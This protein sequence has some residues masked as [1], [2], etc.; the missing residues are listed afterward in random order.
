MTQVSAGVVDVYVIRPYPRGRG[1]CSLCSARWTPDA[2]DRGSPCTATSSR[3]RLPEHAAVRE[4][5]E[6]TGLHGGAP[7]QR[8]RAAFLSAR[9]SNTVELAVV[10]A[11]FVKRAGDRDH[12]RRAPTHEWLPVEAWRGSGSYVAPRSRSARTTL[13]SLLQTRGCRRGRGCIARVVTGHSLDCAY[14][15]PAPPAAGR[16][17]AWRAGRRL[18]GRLARR[19][20]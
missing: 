4:V 11:A 10:F 15:P 7:L 1:A 13:C 19:A 17:P 18:A 8:H 16:P 12:W 9:A 3:T 2:R 6:E 14:G 5:H 20:G